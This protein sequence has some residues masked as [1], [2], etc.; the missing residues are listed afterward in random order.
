MLFAHGT[1]SGRFSSRNRRVAAVLNEAGIATL[2]LDLLTA[3]E[4]TY[5]LSTGRLRFDIELLADRLMAATAWVRELS[6]SWARSVGYFGGSTGA[7]A[8]LTA[9][10]RRPT[11]VQAVV[12]RGGRVDMVGA[13][14][15]KIQVPTLLI[16]GERDAGVLRLNQAAYQELHCVKNLAIVPGATHLFEEPGKLEIVADLAASWFARYLG[17]AARR[18]HVREGQTTTS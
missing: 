18:R 15:S 7:A 17:P 5:D 9:A 13:D 1:G 2:L 14:L 10:L 6:F 8:A 11:W 3:H 12:S 4:E 16:V